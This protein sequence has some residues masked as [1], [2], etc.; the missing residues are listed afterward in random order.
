MIRDLEAFQV[1]F[2]DSEGDKRNANIIPVCL[3]DRGPFDLPRFDRALLDP[4]SDIRFNTREL[5]WIAAGGDMFIFRGGF[6]HVDIYKALGSVREDI[7]M[8]DSAGYMGITF[9][10]ESLSSSARI[11]SGNSL[12]LSD[13]GLLLREDSDRY[14]MRII[15]RCLGDFFD[16]F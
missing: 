6:V 2:T 15:K 8:L 16:I 13:H 4:Q 10:P 11:I 1:S 3:H 9:L 14:K 12:S 5:K 7:K